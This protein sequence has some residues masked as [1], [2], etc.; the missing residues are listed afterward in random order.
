M[1]TIAM[2]YGGRSF[3]HEISV[4]TAIQAGTFFPKEYELLPIYM[5][6]GKTYLKKNFRSF[7][8]YI[9]GTKD[10]EVFLTTGGLR[11]KRKRIKIDCALVCNHG[12]EGE[13]GTLSA[14]L[15]YYDV[16]FTAADSTASRICMDKLLTKTVLK[17]YGFTVTPEW[18]GVDYPCILKPRVLGSSIGIKVAKNEIEYEEAE[19][20]VGNFGSFIV[21]PLLSDAI[22]LNCAVVRKDGKA[23]PSVIEKPLYSGNVLDFDDKYRKGDREI[24]A[25]IDEELSEEIKK[26][27][28][29]IYEK[30]SLFGVV[31][32]D[33][34]YSKGSLFVNEINTVPGSLSYYLFSSGEINFESLLKTLIEEGIK[35]GTKKR[36]Q[37]DTG[38]IRDYA[39]GFKGSKTK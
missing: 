37:F 24:P 6:D 4:L 16:P 13:D 34:L 33:Y 27:S 29:E 9:D 38:I 1:K 11:T 35:R 39:N 10:K 20:F 18:N 12:G 19:K 21:E 23:C 36:P 22:E 32:I 14:L 31:R 8:S 25:E 26:T 5:K 15:E 7:S 17:S 30:L 28:V 2:F 3:E